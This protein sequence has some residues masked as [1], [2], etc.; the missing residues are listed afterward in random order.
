MKKKTCIC[1]RNLYGNG[2]FVQYTHNYY[3]TIK[4]FKTYIFYNS[5]NLFKKNNNNYRLIMMGTVL[6][7]DDRIIKYSNELPKLNC[8]HAIEF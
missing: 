3:N 7:D 5:Y 6:E 1:I 4:E 2:N 8:L